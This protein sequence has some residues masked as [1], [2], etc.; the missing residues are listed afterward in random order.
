[1][2]MMPYDTY[3]LHQAERVKHPEEIQRADERAAQVAA[4]V[5]WLFRPVTLAVRAARRRYPASGHG[6]ASHLVE[7]AA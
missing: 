4:A 1:M 5:S 7:P 3:R 6:G 2:T